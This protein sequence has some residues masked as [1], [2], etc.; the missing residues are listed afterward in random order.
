[1]IAILFDDLGFA[2]LGCYGGLGGRIQTPHI[3]RLASQGLR[4]QNFHTTALCS[5]TRAALLTGRYPTRVGVPKV[6]MPT[7]TGGM[8]ESETTIANA[9]P[10][11]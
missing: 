11:P 3:D 1:M 5:P 6:L 8:D 7:D 4:Y 10:P 9:Y 2:Q